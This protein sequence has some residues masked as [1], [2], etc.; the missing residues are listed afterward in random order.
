MTASEGRCTLSLNQECHCPRA[1]IVTIGAQLDMRKRIK[2]NL[3]FGGTDSET[4]STDSET[5]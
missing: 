4:K 3:Q 1:L 5:S 2:G